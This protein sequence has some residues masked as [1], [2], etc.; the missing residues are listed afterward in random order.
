MRK[1][2][3]IGGTR[4]FG[5][6]L[7]ET[8]LAKGFEVTI[9]TRGKTQDPFSTRVNRI[10]VDRLNVGELKER[11]GN[12]TWD[13]VFDQICYSSQEAMEA[14]E[15]FRDNAKKYVFTSSKSVYDNG[16]R[17]VG[18]VEEDF[19]PFEHNIIQGPK[20]DFTYNE[21]KRQAEA[22]FFQKASFP[23]VAVRFPIVLGL[24]DYTKR[25]HFHIEKIV[26]QEEIHLVNP[27][28]SI[29]F[30]TEEEAGKFLA[31]IGLSDFTGPINALSNGSVKLS[32][33]ITTI[34]EKSQTSTI[35]TATP[36]ETNTSPFNI[37]ESWLMNNEKARNLGFQFR[38]L[39]EWLP[40]LIGDI[41]ESNKE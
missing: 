39:N 27:E 10:T 34:E 9:A 25:L 22:V 29:D 40:V 17:T 31:W 18:Y 5:V 6:H 33:M 35:I 14:I 11:C 38:D 30:I 41:L 32:D 16:N 12:E 36:N 7:V 26:N 1:A 37:S 3:V 15:V 13:I 20:E 4:F 28:A 23:V 21:G 8:L 24:N 2:L 19:N